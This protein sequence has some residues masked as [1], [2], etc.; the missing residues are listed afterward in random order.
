MICFPSPPFASLPWA[1]DVPPSHD[2]NVT[3]TTSTIG[4]TIRSVGHNRRSTLETSN[5]SAW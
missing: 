3:T 5:A 1:W 2:I 4:V